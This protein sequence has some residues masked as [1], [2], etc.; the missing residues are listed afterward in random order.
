VPL[1]LHVLL[2]GIMIVCSR[3]FIG[4]LVLGVLT[5]GCAS[6]KPL[7]VQ[8]ELPSGFENGTS[9][10]ESAWPGQDWYRGFSSDELTTFV[11]RARQNNWDLAGAA[12]RIA[13]ADARARQAGAA[14]LPKVDA[15]GNANYL[16]GHSTNGTAHE[17]D[18][19]ALLSASYE[20]DFWGKNR[21]TANAARF[22]LSASR[23]DRDTLALTTL[24][25]VANGYFQVLALR[26]RLT[27]ARS[28]FDAA[29]QLLEVV[30]AR[31]D[32]GMA[33]PAELASQKVATANAGLQ[34]T[35]LEQQESE[36][37]AALAILVGQVP[38]RFVIVGGPLDSLTEPVIAAGL[39]AELLTRR[40]DVL[41]AEAN[42]QAAHA[43]LAAARAAMFPSFTLTA[44]G[45]LQSPAMNA[46]V[47]TLPGTGLTLSLGASLVQTIFDHGRLRARRDETQAK[48]LELL[49]AYHSAIV[50]ALLDVENALSAVHHLDTAR[51]YQTESLTQSEQA[52]EGAKL[53][54]QAGSGDFL[55]L[56]DAQR[57]LYTARDQSI[58]YKLARLRALVALCKALGGGWTPPVGNPGSA[59]SEPRAGL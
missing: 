11:E 38:E 6:E 51:E 5:T 2:R 35:E 53:R 8:L 26:E 32:V 19:S 24:A 48:D 7:P 22:S 30:Q 54:Y 49:A 1:P 3:A 55:T 34:I 21:A 28:N 36:A 15:T 12:A 31:S 56:L 39:P 14:I 18:W 10:G 52:F 45:G 29:R 9:G 42:L 37:R 33:T 58:Q 17:T 23:A 47:L 4:C 50:A 57:T 43:D 40:P 41:A 59:V 13:Q 16:A 27:I 25:G 20:V 44:G 46:A